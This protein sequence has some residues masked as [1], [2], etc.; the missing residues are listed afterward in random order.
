MSQTPTGDGAHRTHTLGRVPGSV[1][2]VVRG[3]VALCVAA[4]GLALAPAGASAQS[5]NVLVSN[6]SETSAGGHTVAADE[7]IAASFT[8][9]ANPSGYWLSAANLPITATAA[10]VVTVAIYGDSSGSPDTSLATLTRVAS[11]GLFSA[12]GAGVELAAN[13]TYWVVIDKGTDGMLSVGQTRSDDQTGEAGWSIGDAWQN[14]TGTGAWTESDEGKTL[15]LQ[16]RGEARPPVLIDTTGPLAAE[17]RDATVAQAFMTGSNAA[18]YSVFSVGV[19]TGVTGGAVPSVAIYSDSSGLPGTSLHTLTAAGTADGSVATEEIFTASGVDLAASTKYWVVVANSSSSGSLSLRVELP[20]SLTGAM[21]WTLV[22]NAYVQTTTS[23]GI[24]TT[25]GSQPSMAIYG[26][27]INSAP[28]FA[29]ETAARSVAENTYV[30]HLGGTVTVGT[31]SGN[32]FDAVTATD[33]DRDALTY[34]VAATSDSDGAAHLRA[35][36]EDFTLNTRTGQ[37]SIKHDALIDFEDR[38]SYKVKLQVSD[39]DADQRKSPELI[40][41]IPHL[42]VVGL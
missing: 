8:T 24:A 3:A 16:V 41:G 27:A 4:A 22:G 1:R 25:P 20:G 21:G 26:R 13:T 14:K 17:V 37:V 15:R 18:G 36:N 32:V 33:P 39:N 35:F 5:L 7:L 10:A 19:H 34:S 29:A 23:W 12:G 2:R 11:S 40:S 38:S 28:V 9:G 6:S 30:G 42:G 31:F